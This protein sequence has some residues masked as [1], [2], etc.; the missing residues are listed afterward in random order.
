MYP[1][2]Y[3]ARNL[4]QEDGVIFVSIDDVESANLKS[5]LNDVFGE[6]NF[7]ANLLWQKRYVSNATAKHIS[8]M[9]D[10]IMV[11]HDRTHFFSKW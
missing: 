11:F 10:H 6:N 5:L 2:L 1:R 8:D 3:L 4:L 9:H 7:I